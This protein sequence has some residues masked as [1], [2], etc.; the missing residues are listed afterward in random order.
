MC[1]YAARASNG[2]V[3]PGDHQ[4]GAHPFR[5]AE[6]LRLPTGST[7]S[8]TRPYGDAESSAHDKPVTSATGYGSTHGDAYRHPRSQHAHPQRVRPEL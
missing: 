7:E 1:W 8:Q 4:E 5:S 2:K 3:I 6:P